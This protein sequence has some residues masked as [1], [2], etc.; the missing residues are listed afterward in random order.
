MT[1]NFLGKSAAL[2]ALV[3]ALALLPTD[4]E[5]AFKAWI[6]NDAAC[7]G[8][9]DMVVVDDGAGDTVDAVACPGCSLGVINF[10]FGTGGIEVNVNT[11]LSKPILQGGEMDVTYTATN[12]AGGGGTVWLYA[13]DTDFSPSRVLKGNVTGNS[14]QATTTVQGIICRGDDNVD[15][16]LGGVGPNAVND[17]PCTFSAVLSPGVGAV[18]PAFA[19]NFGPHGPTADPYALTI[20][21]MITLPGVQ[22]ATTTGDLLVTPEPASIALFGLGLAGLAAMRR[23]RKA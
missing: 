4:A 12:V 10:S 14:N 6:C 13:S 5:A 15:P 16:V 18:A 7:N 9:G 19:D 17:D 1:R 20:G 3:G 22:G 11:S 2:V 23:R 8:A 21:V